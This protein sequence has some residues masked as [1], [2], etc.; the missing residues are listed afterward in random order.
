MSIW[1]YKDGEAK[2]FENKEDVPKG[3]ADSPAKSQDK[4]KAEDKPAP[5]KGKK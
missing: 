5:K 4:P 3:W 2:L 1:M